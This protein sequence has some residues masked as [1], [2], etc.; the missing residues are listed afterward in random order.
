MKPHTGV[1]GTQRRSLRVQ[2]VFPSNDVKK[3]SRTVSDIFGVS[4][5]DNKIN[6][7]IDRT[8]NRTEHVE[9]CVAN[10]ESEDDIAEDDAK[11]KVTTTS[12]E[13]YKGLNNDVDVVCGLKF[14]NPDSSDT[15]TCSSPAIKTSKITNHDITTAS[16]IEH[17]SQNFDSKDLTGNEEAQLPACENFLE[18]SLSCSHRFARSSHRNADVFSSDILPSQ[19][20]SDATF[21][22]TSS[23]SHT[24]APVNS[25][26]DQTY[27]PL[28]ADVTKPG[29]TLSQLFSGELP[30][31]MTEFAPS[32]TPACLTSSMSSVLSAPS[33][34]LSASSPQ[35]AGS[36]VESGIEDSQQNN[37]FLDAACLNFDLDK[38][39]ENH[40]DVLSG[41]SFLWET[42][43]EEDASP[44]SSSNGPAPIPA[45]ATSPVITTTNLED[46]ATSSGGT[47][48]TASTTNNTSIL[49][50]TT[51]TTSITG[52]NSC[53]SSNY[54]P[55]HSDNSNITVTTITTTTATDDE[56]IVTSSS[57]RSCEERPP[58]SSPPLP[59]AKQKA[60]VYEDCCPPDDVGAFFGHPLTRATSALNGDEVDTNASAVALLHEYINLPAI[61]TEDLK[62]GDKLNGFLDIISLIT[63]VATTW[64]AAAFTTDRVQE[65]EQHQQQQQQEQQQQQQ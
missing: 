63:T 54:I 21:L 50:E 11:D 61:H 14:E 49:T 13:V 3:I 10:Q 62:V 35:H 65:Q 23:P 18:P 32:T 26:D 34:S 36:T 24:A 52:A 33:T 12:S 64:S 7:D 31:D 27:P 4:S 45:P 6:G 58:S 5:S 22:Q 47:S 51:T 41:Y 37:A 20:L 46:S 1:C 16:Q 28:L 29:V 43:K 57:T 60:S 25:C 48:R 19:A 44:S 53:N 38:V 42:L 40:F 9:K 59:T 17:V 30:S 55:S 39:N 15:Q 8:R 2:R 56:E